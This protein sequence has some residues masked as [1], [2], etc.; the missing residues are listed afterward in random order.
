MSRIMTMMTRL[1]RDI[2]TMMAMMVVVMLMMISNA[3]EERDRY[4]KHK[5][6]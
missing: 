1:K 5:G 3:D 4:L 2:M 6:R